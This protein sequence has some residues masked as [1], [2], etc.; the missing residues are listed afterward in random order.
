MSGLAV[1]TGAGEGIGRA[2]ARRLSRDGFGI[3]AVGRSPGPLATLVSELGHV[4]GAASAARA[5]RADQAISINVADSPSVRERLGHLPPVR[6]VVVNAGV[7]HQARLD[8]PDADGTWDEAID[9]NLSGA[10][11]AVRAV[12]PRLAAGARVIF[13]SSGLGQVGRAGYAAYCA[14]KH[15]MLG[16]MRALAL[17]LA[18]R[19]ITVNAV[20]PGWVDTRMAEGDLERTA[21]E[22]GLTAEEARRRACESIPLGRFVRPEEVAE[23][24]A[25]LASEGA[26]AITGQVMNI[27]AGER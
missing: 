17:E 24:I 19:G 14:S 12:A 18:P 4:H 6:V 2:T 7:C 20:C 3:I 27:N 5:D 25:F 23:L 10:W 22:Q 16:L 15:G 13:V 21:A 11:H 9:V 26:S 8:A 1:I